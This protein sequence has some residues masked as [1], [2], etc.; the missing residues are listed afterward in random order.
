MSSTRARGS[1]MSA[2]RRRSWRSPFGG[3]AAAGEV[4][5]RAPAHR[6]G[7]L[8]AAEAAMLGA[9][10]EK[11]AQ[12]R[13]QFGLVQQEGVVPL[14]ALDLDKAD[15]GGHRVE[16][17]H[18]LAA[19]RGREQPV[20]SERDDAEPRRRPGEGGGQRAAMLG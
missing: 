8:V 5:R 1:I 6:A 13:E 15:I 16:R 11:A 9:A 3:A 7:A 19:L 10:G 14:V 2:I 17:M 4:E 18:D 20:A 12:G